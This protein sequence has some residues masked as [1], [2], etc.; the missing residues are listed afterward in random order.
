MLDALPEGE[1]L[2]AGAE[3]MTATEEEEAGVI[4]G[5]TGETAALLEGVCMGAGV[6][7]VLRGTESVWYNWVE[8][9]ET[10]PDIPLVALGDGG[11]EQGTRH[12]VRAAGHGELSGL[13]GKVSLVQI[14][15][16]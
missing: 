7:E 8:L 15:I 14:G 1:A 5:A 13:V 2:L 10:R 3:G 9:E 12:G 6:E 4:E 11:S 16:G